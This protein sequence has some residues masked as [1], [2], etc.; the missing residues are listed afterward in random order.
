SLMPDYWGSA[1]R[2]TGSAALDQPV[3]AP[4][5]SPT[6]R[7]FAA[8][9]KH[10]SEQA[11]TC[12]R[13]RRLLHSVGD[14]LAKFVLDT[15]VES[16]MREEQLL[17]RLEATLRDAL[18]WSHSSDALPRGGMGG[19]P[20]L[21]PVVD[22]LAQAEGEAEDRTRKL[23]KAFGNVDGGMEKLL[24]EKLAGERAACHGLLSL[25]RS[26][27]D[28]EQGEV[29]STLQRPYAPDVRWAT[30]ARQYAYVEDEFGEQSWL[31]VE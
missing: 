27:L 1:P 15:V 18:H 22:E 17:R 10:R 30:L 26:R 21:V 12:V 2:T 28:R 23:A 14:P 16:K 7:L 20:A 4:G 8:V 19:S 24:L 31:Y 6:E 13:L 5:T 3:P 25:I 29:A 11:A 9:Q